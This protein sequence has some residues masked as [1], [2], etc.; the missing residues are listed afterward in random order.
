M[1]GTT[2]RRC[3]NPYIIITKNCRGKKRSPIL[4]AL[5][6][7]CT[8]RRGCE[9]SIITA[10]KRSLG[11]GNIFTP[12]CH[13]VDPPAGHPFHPRILRD[14]V[15]KGAVRILL[16]CTLV[17]NDRLSNH[18]HGHYSQCYFIHRHIDSARYNKAHSL[19]GT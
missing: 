18:L 7:C 15:N 13:S 12:V 5:C 19:I 11:Q 16:L 2:S 17:S 10:H 1:R 14:T 6:K 9:I 3:A 8:Y 4:W